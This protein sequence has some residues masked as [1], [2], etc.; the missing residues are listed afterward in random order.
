[1]HFQMHE[2]NLTEGIFTGQSYFLQSTMVL[3]FGASRF[4]LN[5]CQFNTTLLALISVNV[6]EL[7]SLNVTECYFLNASLFQNT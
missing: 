2:L 3:S 6:M 5:K 4:T 7:D 1:M